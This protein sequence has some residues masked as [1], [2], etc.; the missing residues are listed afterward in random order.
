[1]PKKHKTA[2]HREVWAAALSGAPLQMGGRKDATF[3][4]QGH[5]GGETLL[6]CLFA[7]DQVGGPDRREF[8]LLGHFSRFERQ[9]TEVCAAHAEVSQ[10]A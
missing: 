3:A 9:A 1:M 5:Q 4:A 8:E 2:A 6:R 10:I 7:R